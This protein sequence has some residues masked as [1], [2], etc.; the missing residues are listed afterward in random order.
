MPATSVLISNEEMHQHQVDGDARPLC[1]PIPDFCWWFGAW[2]MITPEGWLRVADTNFA[3][4]LDRIRRR[5]DNLQ[6]R[7]MI[8]PK[9][10]AA[11]DTWA[12]Q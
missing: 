5:F 11:D 3:R 1:P 10:S 8:P 7:G 6:E 4:G 2:W 9:A 12:G